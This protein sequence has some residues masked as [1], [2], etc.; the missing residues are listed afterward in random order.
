MSMSLKDEDCL[1]SSTLALDTVTTIAPSTRAATTPFPWLVP[2]NLPKNHPKLIP[3]A[4]KNT[5]LAS[6]LSQSSYSQL[7]LSFDGPN[8]QPLNRN[9][10]QGSVDDF[11][12]LYVVGFAI[13]WL[14]WLLGAAACQFAG[15]GKN[16]RSLKY[17]ALLGAISVSIP[18][19]TFFVVGAVILYKWKHFFD[20]FS[21]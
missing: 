9:M 3:P 1:S 21:F 6:T 12:W 4:P 10:Q 17:G 14:T 15:N 18:L 2:K 7:D 11:S 19:V 16:H 8:R 13:G 5:P 20:R